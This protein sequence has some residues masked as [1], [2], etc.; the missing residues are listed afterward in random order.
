MLLQPWEALTL[1]FALKLPKLAQSMC[2]Y[3]IKRACGL[4]RPSGHQGLKHMFT[5]DPGLKQLG[6][7]GSVAN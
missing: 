7:S 1:D 5:M 3:S 4:Q 2:K 6:S